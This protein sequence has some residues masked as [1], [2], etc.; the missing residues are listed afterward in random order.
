M[1]ISDF[2]FPK[3]EFPKT[4]D[5]V[6]LIKLTH[7]FESDV[8][9]NTYIEQKIQELSQNIRPTI[10]SEKEDLVRFCDE[11]GR[12]LYNWCISDEMCPI[13]EIEFRVSV[14]PTVEGNRMIINIPLRTVWSPTELQ[15]AN[16]T[17]TY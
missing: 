12:R 14:M 10:F 11:F 3:Q 15:V 8:S 9:I 1:G 7:C 5:Q 4:Y 13:I 2:H 17:F 16:L 6:R